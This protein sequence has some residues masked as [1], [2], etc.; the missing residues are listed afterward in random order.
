MLPNSDINFE[1][2]KLYC[3]KMCFFFYKKK[4]ILKIFFFK[5]IMYLLII[6]YHSTQEVK[7][8]P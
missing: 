6:N 4:G 3:Q 2:S 8:L 5:K 1:K 7:Y